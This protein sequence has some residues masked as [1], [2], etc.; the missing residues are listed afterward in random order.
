MVQGSALYDPERHCQHTFLYGQDPGVACL[1]FG[2][3]ALWLLGFPDQAQQKSCQ[4][5]ALSQRLS[6][7]STAA[8]ALYFAAMLSHCRREP[9]LV[10]E[11]A[12]AA[13]AVA[14]EHQFSFW[15]AGGTIL[16]GW[17]L[18]WER[19]RAEGLAQIHQGLDAWQA[20][21]SQTY[22]TYHLAL[23]AEVLSL[24]R[25]LKEG[26]AVLAQAQDLACR[27]GERFYEAELYRL[28]G[29]LVLQQHTADESRLRE[30]EACFHRSLE[31]A[32]QQQARSL[33]LRGV[34]SLVRLYQQQGRQAEARPLLAKTYGWF[35]EGFDTPDLQEARAILEDDI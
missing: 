20:T 19:S 28:Q 11:R 33:E 21:G 34:I 25:H 2:A 16:G 7:P 1:A 32:R 24:D 9:R 10:H 14:A 26:L 6:Q 18:A 3:V 30:A 5:I 17:A 27:S 31:V 35:N 8:L 23:L 12:D 29:E 15:L 13:R 22:Q 4:A